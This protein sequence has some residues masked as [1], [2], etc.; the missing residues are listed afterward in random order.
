MFAI[1]YEQ[2]YRLPQ[3]CWG[4]F[5]SDQHHHDT[6][7]PGHDCSSSTASSQPTLLPCLLILFRAASV[8][9]LSCSVFTLL[10]VKLQK[11]FQQR[12]NRLITF[13]KDDFLL[14]HN[15]SELLTVFPTYSEGERKKNPTKQPKQKHQSNHT[16]SN[17]N[18]NQKNHPVEANLIYIQSYHVLFKDLSS[19]Y[20]YIFN[21]E[22]VKKKKLKRPS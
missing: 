20:N 21:R 2:S 12:G 15:T 22:N 14:A 1:W 8:Y 19:K 11:W 10:Q 16:P 9:L 3:R 18:T 17:L 13:G 7:E 5:G 6:S 4:I